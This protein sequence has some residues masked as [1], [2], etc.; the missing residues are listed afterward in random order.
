MRGASA[1]D[2][3]FRHGQ[4]LEPVRGRSGAEVKFF[5]AGEILGREEPDLLEHIPSDQHRASCQRIDLMHDV[6]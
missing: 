1:P 6:A 4:A 2:L 5:P 3:R